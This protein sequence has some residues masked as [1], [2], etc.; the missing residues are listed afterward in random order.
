M[1]RIPRAAVLAALTLISLAP[2]QAAAPDIRQ[3]TSDKIKT[4]AMSSYI[5]QENQAEL[6]KIQGD[7]ALAFRLHRGSM[8]YLQPGKLR[9]ES[10]IPMLGSGYYVINGNRKE[11]IGPFY[12][13]VQDIT[14][15]PGK[16]QTLLDF[17]LVPP[18]L[19]DEYNATFLRRDG[20]DY[21]YQLVP[22]QAGETFKDVVWIDPATRVTVK[23]LNYDRDGKLVKWFLYKSA[24]Q[25]APGIYIP[26]QV[27]LYNPENKLAGVT[28]YQNVKVNAPV[29]AARFNF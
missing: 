16:K 14:G 5:T 29:D 24:A 27:E 10:T 2:A 9:I 4:L 13:R 23:R 19:L 17:G 18:E 21:V 22:K 1:F 7:I 11:T 8:E 25:A 15:A 12:H 26:M 20:P 6:K 3:F 28:T